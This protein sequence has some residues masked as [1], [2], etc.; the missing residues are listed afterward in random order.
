MSKNGTE[1]KKKIEIRVIDP[2]FTILQEIAGEHPIISPCECL[3]IMDKFKGRDI[4][5]D[6]VIESIDLI[7][8]YLVQENLYAIDCVVA[9]RDA[10][11]APEKEMTISDIEKEL[12][13]RIKIIK[14]DK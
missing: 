9:E 12:G 7:T 5:R 3:N 13:Y 6:D 10:S 2:D 4:S 14:E 1:M 11:L 8:A